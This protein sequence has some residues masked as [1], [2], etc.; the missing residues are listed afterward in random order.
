MNGDSKTIQKFYCTPLMVPLQKGALIKA[1][2]TR[3]GELGLHWEELIK[4]CS[5]DRP[6]TALF[7]F[8]LKQEKRNQWLALKKLI[9]SNNNERKLIL[10]SSVF[11]SSVVCVWGAHQTLNTNYTSAFSHMCIQSHTGQSLHKTVL[12]TKSLLTYFFFPCPLGFFS[13][14]HPTLS[15]PTHISVHN[16][17]SYLPFFSMGSAP[18]YPFPSCFLHPIPQVPSHQSIKLNIT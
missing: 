13:Y 16:N 14:V 3:F 9:Y 6:L 11:L 4:W 15:I 10:A 1:I 7:L 8:F 18:S 17:S 12:V 5:Q 2:C